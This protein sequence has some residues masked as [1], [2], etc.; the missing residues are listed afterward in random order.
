[1]TIAVSS[2]LRSKLRPNRCRYAWLLFA[3]YG[4][5]SLPYWTV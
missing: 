5:S 1:M 3:V 4:N 2:K